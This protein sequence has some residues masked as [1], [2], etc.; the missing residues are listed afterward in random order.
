[1]QER[2]SPSLS[3]VAMISTLPLLISCSRAFSLQETSAAPAISSILAVFLDVIYVYF[4][5]LFIVMPRPPRSA[6]HFRHAWQK[7]SRLCEIPGQA[8]DNKRTDRSRTPICPKS[9]LNSLTAIFQ[10]RII[11]RL[12]SAGRSASTAT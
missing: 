12:V 3:I 5:K 9:I 8:N 6:H 2:V 1:M 4:V 7:Y 10:R 11:L